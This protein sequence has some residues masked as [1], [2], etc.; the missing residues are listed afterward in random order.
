MIAHN[1]QMVPRA[2]WA[3]GTGGRGSS[4]RPVPLGG[5]PMG[6][7]GLTKIVGVDTSARIDSMAGSA[8]AAAMSELVDMSEIFSA[9]IAVPDW[10]ER[11]G[12]SSRGGDGRAV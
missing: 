10:E 8:V 4:F 9:N 7:R 2:A 5:A 12:R 6:N 11:E 3:R 1:A